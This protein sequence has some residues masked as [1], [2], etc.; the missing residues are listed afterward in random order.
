[1]A[2]VH[3]PQIIQATSIRRTFRFKVTGGGG[4]D[5]DCGANDLNAIMGGVGS[6]ANTTI[7]LVS[8][9]MKIHKVS[10]WAAASAGTPAT[11]TLG[12]WSDSITNPE[13]MR[14]Y[15]DTSLSTAK[16][17]YVAVRPPVGSSAYHWLS[18]GDTREVIRV[19][20]PTGAIVD[21]ECTSVLRNGEACTAYS[22]AAVTVGTYY[23]LPLD[24]P[25]DVLAPVGM[26]TT[27]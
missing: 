7:S 12:F 8:R 9:S 5:V 27:T 3:I 13:L 19:N 1:M 17:A 24:G 20:G 6:V 26:T 25:G 10:I 14:T 18:V 16:P 15:Q 4:T 23:N 11:V 22:A 21:V 2:R